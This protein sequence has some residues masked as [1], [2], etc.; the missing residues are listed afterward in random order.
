MNIDAH[1]ERILPL[2]LWL[3]P[4][5]LVVCEG[6]AGLDLQRMSKPTNPLPQ[7]FFFSLI[8]QI[9]YRSLLSSYI[10]TFRLENA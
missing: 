1:N 10:E 2:F 4:S 6:V 9:L 5:F 7:Q 8:S 3:F